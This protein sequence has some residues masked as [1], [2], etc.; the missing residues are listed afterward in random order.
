[1]TPNIYQYPT[2]V[3][4][5]G[6]NVYSYGIV[7]RDDEDLDVVYPNGPFCFHIKVKEEFDYDKL[8]FILLG[9]RWDPIEIV[10]IYD[11]V[12]LDQVE[13]PAHLAA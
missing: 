6:R 5:N 13:A 1:M 9:L 7:F 11:G 3:T 2:K 8:N 10:A 4:S 12:G